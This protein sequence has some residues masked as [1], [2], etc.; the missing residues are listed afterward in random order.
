MS[1]KW[2]N[3][4]K[5]TEF[6]AKYWNYYQHIEAKF[7]N[8]SSFVYFDKDNFNV[9]SYEFVSLLQNIGAEIDVLFKQICGYP[10]DRSKNMSNYKSDILSSYPRIKEE[11]VNVSYFDIQLQPFEELEKAMKWWKSYNMI[12]H[13]RLSNI[14]EANLENVLYALAALFLL[15]RHLLTILLDDDTYVLVKPSSI[16]KIEGI[17]IQPQIGFIVNED[18]RLGVVFDKE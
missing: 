13:D 18:N 17:D 9:Y 3:G 16:F 2:R 11:K 14:S 4:M 7:M 8:V 1:F 6:E 5:R 15:E 10:G 12:K